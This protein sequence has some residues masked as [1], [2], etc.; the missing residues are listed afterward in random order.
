M[1][2]PKVQAAALQA[3]G[4]VVVVAATNRPDLVD[5]ALL[6]PGRFDSRLYVPP[7][8]DP[9]ERGA[10]LAVLTSRTPLHPDVDLPALAVLT[11][12]CL[13][14]HPHAVLPCAAWLLGSQ[15][16]VPNQRHAVPKSRIQPQ[17]AW[18]R[19]NSR[20]MCLRTPRHLS[21]SRACVVSR[22]TGADLHA[23]VREAT[24]GAL[25]QDT[26]AERVCMRHFHAALQ[27]VPPSPGASLADT[28]MY[29]AFKRGAQ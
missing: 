10:I 15:G 1:S 16:W 27:A 29:A 17:V 18:G 11:P 8:A 6:R 24:I 23:L 4:N 25:E 28:Q 2:C 13:I 9:A 21:T 5:P 19:I 12:G 20:G 7:P 3:R 26:A 22:Y 14:F